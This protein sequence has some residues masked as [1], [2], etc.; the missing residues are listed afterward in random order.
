MTSPNDRSTPI[1]HPSAEDA[2]FVFEAGLTPLE[3]ALVQL[4][5]G[6]CDHPGLSP[7]EFVNL[8]TPLIAELRRPMPPPAPNPDVLPPRPRP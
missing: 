6:T 4:L 3:S 5:K 7:A 2:A 1:P 8:A